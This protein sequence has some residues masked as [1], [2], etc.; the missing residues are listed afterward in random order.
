MDD[1]LYALAERENPLRRFLFVSRVLGKHLPIAPGVGRLSGVALALLASDDPR[2]GDALEALDAVARSSVTGTVPDA[3]V[4]RAVEEMLQECAE[5]PPE[6]L[7]RG[8]VAVLGF[9]ETATALGHAVAEALDADWVGHT[10]RRALEGVEPALD[11]TE[12]HSHAPDQWLYALP[13][14]DGPL[15]LVDDEL[16]TGRTACNLI[17]ALQ[18]AQPRERYVVLALI[19]RLG[20]EEHAEVARRAA[21]IGTTIEILSLRSCRDAVLPDP[22]AP[23]VGAPPL[24]D[25]GA[26]ADEVVV[27]AGGNTGRLGL[28]RGSRAALRR[29]AERTAERHGPADAVLGSGEF[30]WFAMLVADELKA[31]FWSTTRSPIRIGDAPGYPIRAGITFPLPEDPGSTGYLYSTDRIAGR[32]LLLTETEEDAARAQPLAERLSARARSGA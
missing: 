8:L 21:E 17:A 24:P 7:G 22:E 11:F 23:P 16:S 31:P 26:A 30:M 10:T 2:A 14:G 27:V 4:H 28:D 3:E 29:H 13:P 32:V 6:R 19:D 25:D 5:R 15:V 18:R 1:P 9:A 12:D 20:P